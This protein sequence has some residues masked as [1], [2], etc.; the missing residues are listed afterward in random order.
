MHIIKYML[1]KL[2]VS[3]KLGLL[4]ILRRLVAGLYNKFRN[5]KNIFVKVD[6]FYQEQMMKYIRRLD[7][8]SNF[9]Y[10]PNKKKKIQAGCIFYFWWDGIDSLPLI[11]QKCYESICRNKGKHNVIF[12]DKDNYLDYIDLPNIIKKRFD[13]NAISLTLFS[14]VIRLCLLSTYD[15]VWVDSTMYFVDEIP[16]K[17]F[18]ERFVSCK[19]PTII[20]DI[21]NATAIV[22]ENY[23]VYFFI[24]KDGYIFSDVLN[25]LVKYWEINNSQLEYFFTSYAFDYVIGRNSKMFEYSNSREELCPRVEWLLPHINLEYNDEEF[26]KIKEKTFLFKLNWKLSFDNIASNSYYKKIMDGSLK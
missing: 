26:F 8:N 19:S 5:T 4:S 21:N 9:N 24:S 7:E 16:E 22:N 23:P 1:P 13:E 14:D 20:K 25:I 15:C 12:L 17:L 6:T 18:D 11:C 10:F 3:V 2:K